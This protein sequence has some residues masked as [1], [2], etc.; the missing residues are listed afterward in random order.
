MKDWLWETLSINYIFIIHFYERSFL[1][2]TKLSKGMLMSALICGA[3]VPVLCGG[4][5][6][7]AAE[8]ETNDAL[9][10]FRKLQ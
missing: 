5:S 2:K 10:S 3:I 8:A 1:M 6:A 4:T 9:N 7:Y